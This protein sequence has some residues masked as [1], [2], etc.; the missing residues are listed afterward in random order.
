M[1]K[2][3]DRV[4]H[5]ILLDKLFG[6]GVRGISHKWFASYLKNR[7]Q[8]VEIQNFNYRTGEIAYVKS[9]VV[10]IENSIPQGSVTS[11]LL[12]LIYI[13]DL[14]KIVKEMCILFADDISL[15]SSCTSDTKLHQ[16]L[17]TLF[18]GLE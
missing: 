10:T 4:Q 8:C 11:C 5:K 15:L 14:P 16:D 2:A 12:F 1:S 7:E 6:I 9:D 13:N 3:Y 18:D 17:N